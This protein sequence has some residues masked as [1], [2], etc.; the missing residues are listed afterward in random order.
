MQFTPTTTAGGMVIKK[1]QKVARTERRE[2]IKIVF[3]NFLK[4]VVSFISF[5]SSL[6]FVQ[7]SL[8]LLPAALYRH[9]EQK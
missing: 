8:S 7:F 5:D 9:I 6:R 4:N 3:F 1:K 2:K